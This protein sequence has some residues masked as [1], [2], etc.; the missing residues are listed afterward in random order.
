MNT[1]F[2]VHGTG[3]RDDGYHE[4]LGR[5]RKGMTDQGRDDLLVAGISWGT[6][7]GVDVAAAEIALILPASATQG[8]GP[9][10]EEV[11]AQLWS[12][13]LEDPLFELRL[14]TARVP[15]SQGEIAV[16]V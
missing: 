6:L 15:A 7:G 2:F 9:S 16:G 13:L 3:V 14:A 10:G 4:T 12:A 11:R 5:I 1:L 8:L